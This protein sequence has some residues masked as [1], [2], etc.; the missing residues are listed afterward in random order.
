MCNP[1]SGV[2]QDTES[3]GTLILDFPPSRTVRNKCLFKPHIHGVLL[4]QPR[5]TKTCELTRLIL[6]MTQWRC[7]TAVHFTVEGKRGT[8]R[9]NNLSKIIKLVNK[10][11]GHSNPGSLV[12]EPMLSSTHSTEWTSVWVTEW[13]LGSSLKIVQAVEVLEKLEWSKK[14]DLS[15]FLPIQ[16][17]EA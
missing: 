5:Q 10:L 14:T 4:Q 12:T 11:P 13:T 3:A 7:V 17:M 1:R 15:D 9:L 6:T 2:F 16:Q 8:E